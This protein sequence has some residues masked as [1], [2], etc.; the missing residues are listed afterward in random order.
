[1]H[2]LL[3]SRLEAI[4]ASLL[5]TYSGGAGLPNNV[6]G[7][8]REAFVQEFLTK[9]FPAHLRFV[10]GAIIDSISESRSGQI[11]VAV[12]LATA[13][14]FPL[15]AAGN[16]RLVLAENVAVVIEIKSNLSS[17]WKEVL[18]TTTQVRALKKHIRD[19]DTNGKCEVTNIP[20]Y[21]VGYK[22]WKDV[23]ALKKKWEDTDIQERPD[24]VLMIEN[25]AFVSNELW[26]EKDSALI[27]FI[28]H[29]DQR[30]RAHAKIETNLFRYTGKP[31][32]IP[33]D[34]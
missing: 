12:L 27:A 18:S 5:A 14:S 16:Q 3:K 23:W 26:A 10:G 34:G 32:T 28:A 15:P 1:M 8:E 2:P 4:R 31:V 19:L 6:I 17:Q 11:D 7:P 9:V 24:A 30:I 29:L 25:P 21:A 20:V 22:G 13:P 33:T